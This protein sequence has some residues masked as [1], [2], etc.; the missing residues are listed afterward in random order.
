VRY[1]PSLEFKPFRLL[2]SNFRVYGQTMTIS[3]RLRRKG[4]W[5]ILPAYFYDGTRRRKHGELYE[6]WKLVESIRTARGPRQRVVAT[7]GKF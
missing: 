5:P 7:L 6:D 2:V 4:R 1:A 3:G